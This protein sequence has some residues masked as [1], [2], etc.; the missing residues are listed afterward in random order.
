[1]FGIITLG[2]SLWRHLVVINNTNAKNVP[3]SLIKVVLSRSR[4]FSSFDLT[5][6]FCYSTWLEF[7]HA[8]KQ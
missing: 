7:G 4:G 3:P 8:C 5:P 1:M 2:K 6:K